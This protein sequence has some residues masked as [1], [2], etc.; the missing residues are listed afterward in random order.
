[1]KCN[2]QNS[3]GLLG[4]NYGSSF[5]RAS[6]S[7]KREMNKEGREP[8]KIPVTCFLFL[9]SVLDLFEWKFPK[10]HQPVTVTH[11]CHDHNHLCK[12]VPPIISGLLLWASIVLHWVNKIHWAV[13][14]LKRRKKKCLRL[15]RAWDEFLETVIGVCCSWA[16]RLYDGVMMH[17]WVWLTRHNATECIVTH[18][19]EEQWGNLDGWQL[20]H[21]L[22][23]AI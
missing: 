7:Q 19:G 8:M 15:L 14:E 21:M 6:Y 3:L 11:S 22:Q 5:F 9:P 1:M 4:E 17:G 12:C 10:Q 20:N 2:G 16:Q 13:M 18:R 23:K